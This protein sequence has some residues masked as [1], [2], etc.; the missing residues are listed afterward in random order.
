M[1]L[2]NKTIPILFAFFAFFISEGHTQDNPL[3]PLARFVNAAESGDLSAFET[4]VDPNIYAGEARD[5]E[6]ASLGTETPLT[7]ASKNGHLTF[8]KKL[9]KDNR[10][11]LEFGD[12]GCIAAIHAAEKNDG[13]LYVALMDAGVSP[14]CYT[15]TSIKPYSE[16][17]NPYGT[18][19]GPLSVLSRRGYNDL[20]RLSLEQYEGDPNAYGSFQDSPLMHASY[21]NRLDAVQMLLEYGAEPNVLNVYGNSA[22]MFAVN[23]NKSE[24]EMDTRVEIVRLLCDAGANPDHTQSAASN[25][26]RSYLGAAG[27]LGD[28]ALTIAARRVRPELVKALL[29]CGA[30]I[31]IKHGGNMTALE[32]IEFSINPENPNPEI[33]IEGLLEIK[34]LL[35][36]AAKN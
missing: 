6:G 36:E 9:L 2:N 23:P 1:F 16:K 15:T 30:D 29:E 35:D 26:L 13:V 10:L 33:P 28:T 8:V 34:R 27:Q 14:S 21:R 25:S 12:Q 19:Y 17:L 4:G 20:L 11:D 31:T 18:K 22:L 5:A 32:Q 3:N 7:I 24:M